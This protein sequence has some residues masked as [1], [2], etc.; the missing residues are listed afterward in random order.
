MIVKTCDIC[1]KEVQ[2]LNELIAEYKQDKISQ[3]CK[4]CAKEIDDLLMSC[5]KAQQIQRTNF[6]RRFIRKLTETYRLYLQE[7]NLKH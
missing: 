7:L 3:V 4:D 5:M 2:E 6:V 1:K